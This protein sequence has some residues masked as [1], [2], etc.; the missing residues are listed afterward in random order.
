[1][2]LQSIIT[3]RV[4]THNRF[5]YQ[6]TEFPLVTVQL[7]LFRTNCMKLLTKKQNKPWLFTAKGEV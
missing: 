2:N 1:M 7:T 6:D 5:L 4:G 3:D